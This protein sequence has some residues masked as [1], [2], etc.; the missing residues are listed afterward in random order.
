MPSSTI[1]SSATAPPPWRWRRPT[2]SAWSSRNAISTASSTACWSMKNSTPPSCSPTASSAGRKRS[3]PMA[4]ATILMEH[5]RVDRGNMVLEQ[6]R[7]FHPRLHPQGPGQP[8]PGR[9]RGRP[10]SPWRTT[11]TTARRPPSEARPGRAPCRRSTEPLPLNPIPDLPGPC[12]QS[13][14][15]R[16]PRLARG[17]HALRGG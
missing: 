2:P 5:C 17:G 9:E 8:D 3:A 16:R 6:G 13:R 1:S 15:A 14:L 4:T 11:S 10:A 12:R 7:A